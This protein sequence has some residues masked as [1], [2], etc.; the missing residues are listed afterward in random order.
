MNEERDSER[1]QQQTSYPT[2]A[3]KS[4][5]FFSL[6]RKAT[7]LEIISWISASSLV[8]ANDRIEQ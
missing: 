8:L 1:T 5:D 2:L 3:L 6:F 7:K 4:V